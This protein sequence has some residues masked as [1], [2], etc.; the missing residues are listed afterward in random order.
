MKVRSVYFYPNMQKNLQ[1]ETCSER[2]ANFKDVYPPIH[3][4]PGHEQGV[5]GKISLQG[6]DLKWRFINQ[7]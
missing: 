6:R 1:S 5:P 7:D 2:E 4:D 3:V